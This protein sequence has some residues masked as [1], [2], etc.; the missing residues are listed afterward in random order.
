[1]TADELLAAMKETTW[2]LEMEGGGG[3]TRAQAATVIHDALG[4]EWPVEFRSLQIERPVRFS[5][6][7]TDAWR[8]RT[9]DPLGVFTHLETLVVHDSTIPFRPARQVEINSPVYLWRR[10]HWEHWRIQVKALRE[11]GFRIGGTAG[12][13]RTGVH[14]HVGSRDL[15]GR[16]LRHLAYMVWTWEPYIL[17]A[18]NPS[19]FR[20]DWMRPLIERLINALKRGQRKARGREMTRDE[21]AEAW[22]TTYPD[23]LP[24]WS[25]YH[26]SRYHGLNLHSNWFR[27]TIEF[28]WFDSTTDRRLHKT[29]IQ[30]VM[31]LV[32]NAK[33]AARASSKQ[34]PF[35]EASA[36]Y[37]FRV[38]LLRLG[39]IGKEFMTARKYLLLNLPGSAAWKQGSAR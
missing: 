2:G 16:N 5:A 11:N 6:H 17:K 32:S 12:Q 7:G 20:S 8:I 10:E 30:F 29:F 22:Y 25:K 35:E 24:R 19:P 27:Q 34:K 23:R 37:D 15:T 4:A 14:V 21:V 26:D 13:R 39:L 38:F 18:L 3:L 1:M 31:A 9:T 36:K 33:A 28:R